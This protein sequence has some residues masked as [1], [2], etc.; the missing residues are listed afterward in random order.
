MKTTQLIPALAFGLLIGLT[1]C[2]K[3]TACSPEFVPD[4]SS[5][6]ELVAFEKAI[7]AEFDNLAIHSDDVDMT[8]ENDGFPL[9]FNEA[10]FLLDDKIQRKGTGPCEELNLT[11]EQKRRLHMVW[12]RQL[13]CRK[14]SMEKLRDV[15]KAVLRKAQQ[16][17]TEA[18]EAYRNGRIT[19]EQLQGKLQEI[20]TRVR[21]KLREKGQHHRE[22][23]AQ[24]Y[25][26]YT[27]NVKLILGEEDF[28]KWLECRK[29]TLEQR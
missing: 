23:M 17:R 6:M 9:I 26:R 11:P 22:A 28:R 8:I 20:K 3:E 10:G 25:R 29:G 13:D 7:V 1:A 21:A 15:Q 18:I 2:Q 12:E 4:E 5:S 14:G 24:C 19:K 16:D 27:E